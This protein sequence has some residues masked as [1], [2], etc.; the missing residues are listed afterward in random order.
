M[1]N[2]SSIVPSG[3]N[4]LQLTSRA[5]AFR[6]FMFCHICHLSI[7]MTWVLDDLVSPRRKQ[8]TDL[9]KMGE[10]PSNEL[11][12]KLSPAKASLP[13]A[14]RV[15]RYCLTGRV[16]HRR[17]SN[18]PVLSYRL[19]QSGLHGKGYTLKHALLPQLTPDSP[20]QV[21]RKAELMQR[22]TLP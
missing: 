8:L 3:F 21:L 15:V 12:V 14:P 4:I 19:L 11:S 16:N 7:T 2:T 10:R 18:E 5:L 20:D 6:L 22:R 9:L 1:C 17:F 13:F